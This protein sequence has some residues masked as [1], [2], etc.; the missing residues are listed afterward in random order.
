VAIVVLATL[1]IPSPSD[2]SGQSQ[3]IPPRFGVGVQLDTG[4]VI[5]QFG[6]DVPAA[7]RAALHRGFGSSVID[8]I[9]ALGIE[10]L[11]LP[12]AAATQAVAAAYDRNP[13]VISAEPD[14]LALPVDAPNAPN[15]ASYP[16]Q[17]QHTAVDS[18][19]AW[20]L[21]TGAAGVR[22]TVCDTGVEG[23][24]PDLVNN[25]DGSLGYNTVD[26]APG[27]WSPIH[28]HGT[29]VAGM[30]AAEGNNSIGVAGAA[31]DATIIPVR[32][33]NLS[34][35]GAYFSDMADCI[36][37]G[38]DLDSTAINLS[39]QTY[40]SGRISPTILSA[41]EYANNNGSVLIVAA[42]NENT[43]AARR[44]DKD[45]VNIV[46]VSSIDEGGAK[47]SFSNYGA[48]IDIA[49]PGR[50]VQSTYTNSTYVSWSGTSFSAPLT[51]GVALLVADAL[52]VSPNGPND[53]SCIRSALIAGA[54][55]AGST[56][57]DDIYGSGILNSH[58]AVHYAG[59]GTPPP[60]NEAPVVTI[61][62]PAN[63][64]TYDTGASISF[65]G[66][67]TDSE[68][69]SLTTSII[70][71]SNL[72]GQIG[73][74]GSF[75]TAL[76]DGTHLLTASVTDSGGR[77]GSASISLTVGTA[78]PA[79]EV[80]TAVRVDSVSYATEGGRRGDK[81]L[82]VTLALR[83]D[84]NDP[85]ANASVS[86]DLL[87]D[88]SVVGSGTAA[89]GSDGTVTFTSKNAP[90][91]TY[92]TEVTGLVSDLTWDGVTPDNTYEK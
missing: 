11:A 53:A 73:T 57:E 33:S 50:D 56:G 7:E 21:T 19:D 51:A 90:S 84:L 10:V 20:G 88:G 13:L 64:S 24:H 55:D 9:P 54:V 86:I 68:D 30:I 58:N 78:P 34:S 92:T 82:L 32:I 3:V 28:P 72:S 16:L 31:W 52:G 2:A 83:D 79:P 15:D 80:G 8:T 38:T 71:T 46:Y 45:P 14:A 77:S 65:A 23:S 87:R 89:T 67:A 85:V 63:G 6:P 66:T 61:G 75:S 26:N 42:G 4:R 69:G 60:P 12:N 37:Y 35:G 41:A 81:H 48:Y 27:N 39:Y 47:S 49:A 62:S 44:G 22:A 29:F 1:S 74:G 76:S 59:C 43:R 91:G 36:V 40:S 5:V 25:L 17:W 70:W 18:A